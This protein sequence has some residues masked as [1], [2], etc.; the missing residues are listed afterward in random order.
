MHKRVWHVRTMQHFKRAASVACIKEQFCKGCSRHTIARL[1]FDKRLADGK[2]AQTLPMP[3][4]HPCSRK[5]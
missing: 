5:Q 1:V 2:S 4:E 3:H